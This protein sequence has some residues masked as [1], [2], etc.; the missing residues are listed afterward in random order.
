[1]RKQTKENE[2]IRRKIKLN[3]KNKIELI[4]RI[5]IMKQNKFN[6]FF[7]LIQSKI[8]KLNK[9]SIGSVLITREEL[10]LKLVHYKYSIKI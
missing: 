8:V 9:L 4:K 2:G 1:M 10:N 3:N 7:K 5:K 6:S